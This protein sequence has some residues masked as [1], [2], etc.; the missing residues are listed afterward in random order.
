MTVGSSRQKKK[1][2]RVG[3]D[4]VHYLAKSDKLASTL[5]HLHR[6]A[7]SQECHHL[8]KKYPQAVF[9][10]PEGLNNCLHPRN[11][12]MVIRPPNVDYFIV[13]FLNLLSVIGDIRGKIRVFTVFFY[14][15]PVLIIPQGG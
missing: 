3:A 5:G 8:S 10:M 9:W 2:C 13:S 4:L 6:L 7:T 14:D 1:F 11:V 12:S 15:N